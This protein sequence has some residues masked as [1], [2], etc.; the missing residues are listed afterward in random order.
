M[1]AADAILW[2]PGSALAAVA[3]WLEPSLRLRAPLLLA[4]LLLWVAADAVVPDLG[5]ARDSVRLAVDVAGWRW[6][7][8]GWL[9]AVA[10]L[11]IALRG[12]LGAGPGTP[13]MRAAWSGVS[14]LLAWIAPP[15]LLLL[16]L[17]VISLWG[18]AGVVL[19]WL[20]LTWSPH[21]SVALALTPWL[22]GRDRGA[23]I[24]HRTA[25]LFFVAFLAVFGAYTLYIC[26][27]VMIH[28]DEAQYLRV[29]QSLLHDGDIDLANNL[30]G[31]VTEFHVMDVGV[32]RAPGSPTGKIYSV[33]PVGLSLLLVPAYEVG[34]QLWANPRLG[35]ALAMAACGAAVAALLYLW[36]CH[37][38]FPSAV[39][40]WVTLACATTTPL[41]LFSTQIYPELPTVLVTLVVLLRLDPR[42][43]R[44]VSSPAGAQS[45]WEL[46][47][48]SLLIGLFPFLHPRYAPL[49]G[50][51]GLGL[52]WQAKGSAR[53][54]TNLCVVIVTGGIC[55]AA[56]LV[57]NLSFS[58]DWLGNF[59]PGNA[60]DENALAPGT[61][62]MSLPGHWIHVTKGLAINSPWYFVA[63]VTGVAALAA[64]RD[65]RLLAAAALYATTAVVN[66]IHPEW[67]FGFCLP[68]RFVVTALPALALCAAAGLQAIRTSRWLGVLLCG[69]LAFSWD[70][71]GAAVQIPEL[72][73]EGGHL[74]RTALAG[75]YPFG[76]HGFSHT[77]E[78]IP[79]PDLL[80]WAL[81]AAVLVAV[82][83]PAPMPRWFRHRL[84]VCAVITLALLSP[85][86]WGLADTSTARLRWTV[87][88]YLKRLTDG[89]V[90]GSTTL[91]STFSRL[92]EGQRLE[93]GTFAADEGSQAGTLAAYYMPIQIPG[94]YRVV[95]THVVVDGPTHTA[96]VSHQR[97]LPALQPWSERLRFP[98]HAGSDGTFRFDYYLDRLQLGYLHFI[99]S[100]TGTLQVDVTTQDVHPLLLDL[101]L[102]ETVRFDFRHAA[103]P[104]SARDNLEPGR[105]QARFRLAGGALST[106]TQHQPTPV[107]MAVVVTDGADVPFQ[108]LQPWYSSRRRLRDIIAGPD[109]V[110]P[111]RE[112]IAAPWWTSIPIVGVDAYQMS[113][114]VRKSG[115]VWF[116]F[117]YDGPADLHLEEI[118]VHRQ[119]LEME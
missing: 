29:T 111:Q 118:V 5:F 84:A 13:P 60:W 41:L 28:G 115:P 107:K 50:L 48:L 56:L 81:A 102:E 109:G 35:T 117:Q 33:H 99:Y 51:L 87:S 59:R 36:L 101:R 37:A 68:A 44:P 83:L 74:P 6:P 46:G 86:L 62:L 38:G 54:R 90:E 72:A 26:Q 96:Y 113:F 27:M 23:A 92:R 85:A 55:V 64:S 80:L 40:S 98:I 89:L 15:T 91:H 78:S 82:V 97:T 45:P 19:P 34:L 24:R 95:A 94:L 119:H 116:L 71:V 39:S 77:I 79:L 43:L 58:A 57:Y 66:G 18:P 69:A 17:R 110:Q 106:L 75:F 22:G 7:V 10:V 108:Q 20:G 88:P 32:H 67:T 11:L 61:W 2:N 65:R 104:H 112:L 52:V 14:N 16:A 73:Y 9:P 42:W 49:A 8:W 100:G 1:R 76:I 30:S 103:G 3:A 31:D 4:P 93:D 25:A 114:L 105:Y 53:R 21:A 70:A 12:A 63:V 47:A